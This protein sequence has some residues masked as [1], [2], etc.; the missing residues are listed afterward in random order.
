MS[1]N[2]TA[3]VYKI[4]K[5][6]KCMPRKEKVLMYNE[7]VSAHTNLLKLRY[8]MNVNECLECNKKHNL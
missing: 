6:G 4:F 7:I 2:C 8:I 1:E 3:L 5:K